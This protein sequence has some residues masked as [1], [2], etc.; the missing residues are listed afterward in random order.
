MSNTFQLIRSK[1]R[2]KS[3]V[4]ANDKKT[5]STEHKQF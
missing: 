3:N 4:A 5:I 2:L 1:I